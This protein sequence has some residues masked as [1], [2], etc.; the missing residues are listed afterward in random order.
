MR[1]FLLVLLAAGFFSSCGTSAYSVL[2]NDERYYKELENSNKGEIVSGFET[3][4]IFSAVYLPPKDGRYADGEYFLAGV[5]IQGDFK[6]QSK[7][8]L[9]N[10]LFSLDL[11]GNFTY[12]KT[13]LSDDDTIL[14]LAPFVDRWSLYY[15]VRFEP[16]AARVL[17]LRFAS[18]E[19]AK[20]L[21]FSFTKE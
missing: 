3:K 8:G 16:S 15:I 12:T 4:A 10:P 21:E 14:K 2:T 6:E 7:R 5:Y 19:A 17:K 9:D 20:A 13:R 18:K 1:K 11:S